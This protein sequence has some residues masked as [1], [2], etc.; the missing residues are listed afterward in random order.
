MF[1]KNYA[2]LILFSESKN[3]LNN[4]IEDAEWVEDPT[5]CVR[6]C[7]CVDEARSLVIAS[8]AQSASKRNFM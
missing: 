5:L 6:P 8:K 4:S 2:K 1:S 7:K 3:G